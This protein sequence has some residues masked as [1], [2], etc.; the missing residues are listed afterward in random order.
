MSGKISLTVGEMQG[1][2]RQI[3]EAGHDLS[4][5]QRYALMGAIET[6][7]F[8]KRLSPGLKKAM[9]EHRSAS[10]PGPTKPPTT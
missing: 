5:E 1:C 8:L 4:S 10:S 9:E 3:M 7:E 6:M 2:L